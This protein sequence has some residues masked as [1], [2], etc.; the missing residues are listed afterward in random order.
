[1]RIL[2]HDK[3]ENSTYKH[4]MEFHHCGDAELSRQGR[5]LKDREW[6]MGCMFCALLGASFFIAIGH[7]AF[8]SFF[9]VAVPV[10]MFFKVIEADQ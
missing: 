4:H 3:H 7:A 9:L 5:M 10:A 2:I 1:M 8:G 6:F